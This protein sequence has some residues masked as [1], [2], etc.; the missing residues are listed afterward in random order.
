MMN[1]SPLSHGDSPVSRSLHTSYPLLQLPGIL[2][3]VESPS[4]SFSHEASG[5]ARTT[6]AESLALGSSPS[7]LESPDT[8]CHTLL[9][10][11]PFRVSHLDFEVVSLLSHGHSG[12]VVQLVRFRRDGS[13]YAMKT[14]DKWSLVALVNSGDTKAVDRASAERD[15]HVTLDSSLRN[16]AQFCPYFVKFYYS[17]QTSRELN[18]VMEYCSLDVLEYLNLFGRLSETSTLLFI[19]EMSMAVD[20]LHVA[21]SIHRDIKIENIMISKTGHTKLS[22][23][24]SSKKLFTP[25]CDSVVGFSLSIMPPEFFAGEPSYGAAI[26][27]FQL[28]I[29]AYQVLTGQTPFGGRPLESVDSPSWP[30]A[31]DK[32][33]ACT[34]LI[35]ALLHPKEECRLTNLET[36]KAH[37]AMKDISWE[38]HD[39]PF[40]EMTDEF[41][42]L[43]SPTQPPS[44][45]DSFDPL[46]LQSFSYVRQPSTF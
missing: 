3:R 26:D 20:F 46:P 38:G 5:S 6:V 21:G 44:P 9:R 45:E 23:F 32:P 14:V 31:Y 33:S 42:P 28:G 7:C 17:F 2:K 8:T 10:G 24:G 36:I 35:S 25:R 41:I 43:P 11:D 16:R 13:L 12:T 18:Y 40:P 1:K 37:L 39:A 4:A 29:C 30:P 19:A 34:D 27:W 22:D 15:L